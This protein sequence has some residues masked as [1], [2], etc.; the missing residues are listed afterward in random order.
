MLLTCSWGSRRLRHMSDTQ[1]SQVTLSLSK[2]VWH[3]KL[4]NFLMSPATEL[5]DRNHLCSSVIY[6]SVAELWLVSCLFTSLHVSCWFVWERWSNQ[7]SMS[8]SVSLEAMFVWRLFADVKLTA[9]QLL[10]FVACLTW[11]L[12]LDEWCT[13]HIH[14]S[15]LQAVSHYFNTYI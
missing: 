8:S 10:D 14:C 15:L 12:L 3:C 11:A 7:Q 2:V 5:L 6:R 9:R 1:Q 13:Q 4:L